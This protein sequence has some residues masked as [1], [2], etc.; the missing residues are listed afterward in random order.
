VGCLQ[1]LRA[2]L[3]GVLR[4]FARADGATVDRAIQAAGALDA[5]DTCRDREKL[6]GRPALPADPDRRAAI[7]GLEGRVAELRSLYLTERT[8]EVE[9]LAPKVI[10]EARA[11]GYAPLLAQA[12]T[13]HA[14]QRESEE[15]R[16]EALAV[17]AR[18]R[19]DDLVLKNLGALIFLVGARDRRVD[20]ALAM[21]PAAEAVLLR[22]GDPPLLRAQ[23]I[24]NLA[25]VLVNK[26]RTEDANRLHLQAV[27]LC[28]A[29]GG[30]PSERADR[31][32]SL[33]VSLRRSDRYAEAE[34]AIRRAVALKEEVFGP[35]HPS[36]GRWLINLTTVLSDRGDLAG[37]AAAGRG[38]SPSSTPP[39]PG[40]RMFAMALT[41]LCATLIEAGDAAEALAACER[42]R[43]LKEKNL[44][45]DHPST[46]NT[47]V[48][49]GKALIALGRHAEAL[50]ALERAW[51]STA[52]RRSGNAP[53]RSSISPARS[54]GWAACRR[55]ARSSSARGGSWRRRT[56]G[57]AANVRSTTTCLGILERREGHGQRALAEQSQ[58]LELRLRRV[59]RG[60]PLLAPI[61]REFDASRSGGSGA[62]RAR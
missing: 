43:A 12:L 29:F 14:W 21:F 24:A 58:A 37:A 55:H 10:D 31:W 34:H 16:R 18:A 11:I 1:R 53:G 13:I 49:Q 17:S 23:L 32:N 52:R 56:S 35:E 33:A 61:Q 4:I 40:R 19:D 3:E 5:V 9:D 8:R 51:R 26:N 45:A 41:N 62:A 50:E 27:L 59:G 22:A 28:D 44:K 54:M 42:G 7:A 39:P 57:K 47:L 15:A 46:A 20:E 60:H 48:Q 2:D 6:L 25:S 36:V 38:R 30:S